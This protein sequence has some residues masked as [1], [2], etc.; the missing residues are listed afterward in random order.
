MTEKAEAPVMRC[1]TCRLWRIQYEYSPDDGDLRDSTHPDDYIGRCH[2]YPPQLDTVY[3]GK[4]QEK[5]DVG[6]EAAVTTWYQ[7]LTSAAS[8]CGEFLGRGDG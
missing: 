1:D 3:A 2:R 6:C 5:Y 7:P 8:W 4:L